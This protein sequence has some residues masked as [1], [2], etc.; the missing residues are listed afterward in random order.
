M[1]PSNKKR[2]LFTVDIELDDA[3]RLHK[4]QSGV[5][6]STLVNKLLRSYLLQNLEVNDDTIETINRMTARKVKTTI[7]TT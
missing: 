6:A 5:A 4:E 2:L 3:L 7:K 1:K